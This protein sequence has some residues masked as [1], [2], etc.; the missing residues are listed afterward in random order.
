MSMYRTILIGIALY[1]LFAFSG[2][3]SLSM[4]VDDAVVFWGAAQ[5]SA[6]PS[7]ADSEKPS[8]HEEGH[9]P[10]SRRDS[11]DLYLKSAQG[12]EDSL[13]SKGPIILAGMISLLIHYG[14]IQEDHHFD[15]ESHSPVEFSAPQETSGSNSV[16]SVTLATAPPLEPV[17]APV[18]VPT[19]VPEVKSVQEEQPES[20]PEPAHEVLSSPESEFASEPISSHE[21][22]PIHAP[23]PTTAPVLSPEPVPEAK[24]N[25]EPLLSRVR[26]ILKDGLNIHF[27]Y[28]DEA[29]RKKWEGEVL[30]G[31]RISPMGSLE[32]IQVL[33]SSGHKILDQAAA[34]VLAKTARDLQINM[35]QDQL[36]ALAKENII[37]RFPV[38]YVLREQK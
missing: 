36:E 29:I 38:R 7:G 35:T 15:E 11:C 8:P 14:V 37:Y 4:N 30:L 5:A 21:A 9:R 31:F 24:T 25:V 3:Q 16:T 33:N 26:V 6:T 1:L 32:E 34:D 23:A 17:P 18:P 2:L 10:P 22:A 20:K 19:P 28:P 27:F 12:E 13:S